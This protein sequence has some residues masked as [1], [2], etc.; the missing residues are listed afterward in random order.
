MQYAH[1]VRATFLARPNRFV[2]EAELNGE[3]V[4]CHVKNTGRCRELLVPGATVILD[5]QDAPHRAT[6]YDLVAVYKGTR[7]INMDSQAPNKAAASFLPHLFPGCTIRPEVRCGASRFDFRLDG[8]QTGY[9]E[10]KGVTLEEDGAVY[11][12]DAPTA[13]GTR[14]VLE[15]CRC[16]EAGLRAWLLFVVQMENVRYFAPN[17]RTDPQFG[18]ALRYAAQ[19]GVELLAYDCRV[20]ETDMTL[21]RQVE[22]RL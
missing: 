16:A 2:A 21:R 17:D 10:V 18:Q 4:I 1:T 5:R 3:K 15:L 6:P 19:H 11:F 12:P 22:I 7:L 20:T 13:R 8:A 14:H 9:L